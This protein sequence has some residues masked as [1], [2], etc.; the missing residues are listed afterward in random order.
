MFLLPHEYWVVK[1][2][3]SSGKGVFAK[4]DITAGSV[5]GDYLG[6]L[7]LD[8]D[9]KEEKYGLYDMY[10]NEKMCIVPDKKSTGIHL[11]NH[12]CSANCDMYPY[13]G[14]TLYFATRH[15]FKGEELTVKYLLDPPGK[16][17]I[18]N[19]VCFCNSP[20]CH[21]TFHTTIEISKEADRF[22]HA[23]SGNYLQKLPVPLGHMLPVLKSYPDT[24]P[25][26]EIFDVYGSVHEKP[27]AIEALKLPSTDE[28]R[29]VIRYS[30]RI[31]HFTNLNLYIFGI[32]ND[33]I[34]A[35]EK[36]SFLH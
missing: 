11:I 32:A 15:I 8:K 13:K 4:K 33:L 12:S 3:P 18:C 23:H 36:I 5:I 24:I 25:E 22:I 7:L 16:N 1:N 9:F 20:V 29:K 28:L 27:F 10:F 31:L 2:T 30:G 17:H 34:V 35:T 26:S 19:H 6:K 14:H 21:G